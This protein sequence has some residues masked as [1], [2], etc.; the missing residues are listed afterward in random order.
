MNKMSAPFP[1]IPNG[2]L[3]PSDIKPSSV[4]AT[5][6]L[7]VVGD[8]KLGTTTSKIGFYGTTPI[9]RPSAAAVITVADLVALLVTTGIIAP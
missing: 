4:N 7:N 3:I 6:D 1:F 9:V 5:N 8:A 2:P